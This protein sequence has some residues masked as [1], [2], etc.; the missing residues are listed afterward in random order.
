[1]PSIYGCDGDQRKVAEK[2][3]SL[4]ESS[5][6]GTTVEG[7][8]GEWWR[9][10]EEQEENEDEKEE[11]EGERGGGEGGWRAMREDSGK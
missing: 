2:E 9:K 1:M 8:V 7:R 5:G 3:Q 6:T 11:E 4:E 10:K